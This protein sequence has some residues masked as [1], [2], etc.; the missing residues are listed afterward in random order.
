MKN[1]LL[2][3]L[4]ASL[5][6]MGTIA[7]ADFTAAG[8]EYSKGLAA[9]EKWTEDAANE[10]ISLPNSFACIISNSGGE[11]NANGTWTALIDEVACGLADADPKSKAVKYSRSAM[12][13]SRA[14]NY[15]PQETSAWFNAQGGMRYI[16]DVTLKQSAA[17]LAPFGEWYFSFYNAGILNGGTWT[18]YT[19]DTSTQ[20]G[21]VDIGPSGDDVSILVA[22]EGK[23]FGASV[24]GNANNFYHRDQ[25]AKVLFVE[26]SSANTKFLGKA[27]SHETVIATGAATGGTTTSYVAGA[28]SASHY[29]RRN[30]DATFNPVGTP[31][32]FDRSQQFETVH[33]SGLY[34]VTTG[35]KKTL[36][37]G[38]GFKKSDGTRGYLGQWGAWLDSDAATF[39]PTNTSVDVTDDD[40]TSFTL[41]WSP[42]RII[43]R[44]FTD[45]TLSDGDT[46]E[47]FWYGRDVGGNWTQDHIKTA[48]WDAG[49]SRFTFT[50][51]SDNSTMNVSSSTWGI[52]M[53]S[54]VKR[55]SVVWKTGTTV[56]MENTKNVLFSSTYADATSTKFVSQQTEGMDH[57]NPASLPYS[58]AAFNGVS[59]IRDMF[60]HEATADARKT[61][62]LTGSTPGTGLEANTLYLDNGDD[63]L[64]TA[65]KPVRFDFSINDKQEKTTNYS[66]SATADYSINEA[67]DPFG[68]IDLYLA[69]EAS[70]ASP[71]NYVWEFSAPNW[72]H[73]TTAYNADGTVVALDDPL[74]INYTYVATDDRNNGMAMT[75]VSEDDNNPL[76]GCTVSGSVSTCANVQAASYAGVKFQLEY[77]GMRVNGMPGVEACNAADCSGESYYMQ[78]V[79]LKDGTELTDS[80]GDKYAFL[81]HAVSS[82]FKEAAGGVADCS[83]ISFT[84]LADLGIAASDVPSTI[85]RASTDYPLP[86]SAW[87]DEPTTSNC[88]VTMGDTSGCN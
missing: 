26:G 58:L 76:L 32:C 12:K 67:K 20:Y 4:S 31:A 52:W 1:K 40:A 70:G 56:K 62:F 69:S 36:N 9:Q 63:A 64:T 44:S 71:T 54:P 72:A 73:S 77:D 84:T 81:G 8:T 79:N 83:A 2:V 75:I 61:Y 85:D 17:T 68:R 41:K 15:S 88:T 11:D 38:F 60:F 74:I 6:S 50:K 22:E 46:F 19:T 51:Q 57:T 21:Y 16:A 78:L 86:S 66:D 14:S 45:D 30:L 49:N 10:F 53:W 59:D 24:G 39:T 87:A 3:T 33:D 48:V 7:A 42:G 28:T 80:K 23:E 25:Y 35:A 13:S 18:D 47:D 65:D 55:A 34:N 5:L 29:Y 82:V 37:A 27:H 43:Q